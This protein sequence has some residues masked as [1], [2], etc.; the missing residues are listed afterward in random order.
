MP[1]GHIVK[2]MYSIVGAADEA[3]LRDRQQLLDLLAN[4]C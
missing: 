4:T 1:E 2:L 3:T